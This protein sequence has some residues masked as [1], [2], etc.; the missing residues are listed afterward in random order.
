MTENAKRICDQKT[1]TEILNYL[2]VEQPQTLVTDLDNS[3]LQGFNVT[4]QPM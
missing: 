3:T 2:F 1:I 4:P